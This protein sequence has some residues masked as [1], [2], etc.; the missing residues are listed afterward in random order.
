[1]HNRLIVSN[2]ITK[3]INF[4]F[5]YTVNWFYTILMLLY[6]QR[7]FLELYVTLNTCKTL[8]LC[9]INVSMFTRTMLS[10]SDVT[11][12]LVEGKKLKSSSFKINV[13]VICDA[14]IK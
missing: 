5:Q 4:L 13:N 9:V 8:I 7:S 2:L 12:D 1:M 11:N 10:K 6:L 3:L 14:N